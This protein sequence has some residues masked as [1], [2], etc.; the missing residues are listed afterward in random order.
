MKRLL[1]ASAIAGLCANASAEL[2]IT[3]VI[4]GPLPGG[5]PKAVELYASSAIADL[6]V[7]GLESANNGAA[8]SGAEFTFPA[9]A[10]AA[11]TFLYVSFESADFTTFFGFAPD[12]TGGALSINGDDA[13]VLYQG[14]AISDVYG[15]VGV[16]GTGE[17]WDHLD[18]W[19]YRIDGATASS[20]FD[21]SQW[22]FSGT[23]ALDGESDN[24][25]ASTP[26]PLASYSGS[27][28][29]PTTTVLINEVDADTVGS[30]ALEFVELFDGGAGNAALDGL[31]VVFFNGSDDQSYRAFDLD[32]YST[33]ADGYFV[34]G[35]AAVA[36]VDLVFPGNG[37]Q[38][39]AD[40]VALVNGDAA[41]YPNDTAIDL[42][43][44]VD[45]VVYDTNDSDD[46]G[47]LVLLNAGQP[48]LNEGG[49]GDKDNHSNQRCDNGT[50]GLRNTDTFIQQLASPGETNNC[51][52]TASQVLISAI[53]GS[54]D[55]SS[56]VGELVEVTAIVVGDFQDDDADESRNLRGFYLQ[57]EA[58]DE[59]GDSSTSEGIF[60]FDSSFGVNVELGDRVT[61]TGVVSEFFGETQIGGVSA[62]VVEDTDALGDVAIASVSLLGSTDVT[63][64]QDGDLQPDLERFEG[65]LVSFPET[66]TITEQFQLDRFNEIKL[67]AGPRPFQ[68]TQQNTPD[69]ILFAA[70]QEALGARRITYDDGLSQQN[71]N[72]ANLDGFDPYTDASA[73]RMGDT[74]DNL[75]GVLIY[76]W[77]GSS[78]SGGTWRVVSPA[79]GTNV[80]TSTEDG[81]SPNPRPTAPASVG[82]NLSI[83]SFNVLNF[84]TTLDT[85]GTTTTLG[86]NPRGADNADEFERQK[87]KLV[88]ALAALD[89][90]IVGL[91]ELEN[92]FDSVSDGSTAIEVLVNELNTRLGSEVYDYVFPGSAHVGTDAIAVGMIYKAEVVTPEEGAAPAILD[93][94]V[95]ETLDAFVGRDFATDPIFNGPNTNRVPLAVTFKH[96]ATYDV[97]TV[98][99]NHFKSK[100]GT[101]DSPA[102]MDQADG[103]GAWNQRRLDAAEALEAWLQTAP[104]GVPTDN[105]VLLG[106]LNAYAMEDPVQ[107]LLSNGFN[108]VEDADGYSFTFDGQIGTLD[109]VLLSDAL[110]SSLQG[111]QVWHI[112][113][114]EADALDYNLDFGRSALYFDGATATRNSDHDPLVVGLYLSTSAE[115][116]YN[117]FLKLMEDGGLEAVGGSPLRQAFNTRIFSARLN[118]AAWL[119][120]LDRNRGACRMLA[121]LES[122][123]DGENRPVDLVQGPQLSSFNA[124]LNKALVDGECVK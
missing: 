93:D 72:I 122:Y 109:Y 120:N 20:T 123:A 39:G 71:A 35:N 2:L 41:D 7:Y 107:S 85:S 75:T 17:S 83:A 96:L 81:N 73:K 21:D 11:G 97:V 15:E 101:G 37:L 23:N 99:A 77:A 106:D 24:A 115:D 92:E 10:V 116:V 68:F 28:A 5:E 32:G 22:T 112:N 79:D 87:V 110:N 104:T 16:D 94:T 57:E 12:Y 46:A 61:V 67:V 124:L 113:S 31:S 117:V 18:G 121:R 118:A 30:D 74:I 14:G 52:P 33:D 91:V 69:P 114:D 95:A 43:A 50:G 27:E 53:Q 89:A 119:Q 80:F 62:V 45:A 29:G 49:N 38:N 78:S 42:G 63:V 55:T 105:V 70:A 36:N 1:L 47:L 25:S 65:M 108:N 102:N 100:G 103:A 54:T 8:A 3:G 66:L 26:F 51:A 60:V 34:L 44:V 64:S 111:A 9:D 48:Q 6:S 40:A 13:I 84:F 4:D 88:N 19:A 98:V 59:D 58:S 76:K 82:G 90:D 86:F 56:M